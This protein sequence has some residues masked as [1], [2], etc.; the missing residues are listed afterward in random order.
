M[1]GVAVG[2]RDDGDAAQAAR[3]AAADDAAGDLAAVGDEDFGEHHEISP[4]PA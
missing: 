3:A 1:Q 2:G 4:R